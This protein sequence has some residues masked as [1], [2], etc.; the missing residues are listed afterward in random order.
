MPSVNPYEDTTTHPIAE[1]P[2]K[3]AIMPTFLII[4][5]AKS[6]STS[7]YHALRQ[8]PQVYMSPIKEPRFFALEGEANPVFRRPNGKAFPW[9][10]VTDARAYSRLF[11]AGDKAKALGEASTLYLYSEKAPERIRHYIPNAKLIVVLRNPVERA[12]SHFCFF[13]KDGHEP[14]RDFRRV[15]SPDEIRFRESLGLLWHYIGMGF[16]FEQLSRYY[17]LFPPEQIKIFLY[18]D[19]KTQPVDLLQD[20][21]RFIGVNDAVVPQLTEAYNASG[22]PKIKALQR[23]IVEQ[24]YVRSALRVVLPA[25]VRREIHSRVRGFNLSKP[26]PLDRETRN[27]LIEIYRDDVNR[28]QELIGRDLSHWMVRA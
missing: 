17:R 23:L 22:I 1:V 2:D 15:I 12:Y 20:V 26:E 21:F 14:L 4:G 11:E 27:M 25:N 10:T 3:A 24:N 6:G 18:E 16:Y 13:V 8:H 5:A 9:L 19:W 7:L 28:L